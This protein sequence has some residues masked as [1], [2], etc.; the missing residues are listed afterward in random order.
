MAVH[1]ARLRRA[2]PALIITL[3]LGCSSQRREPPDDTRAG[4]AARTEDREDVDASESPS[5]EELRTLEVEFPVPDAGDIVSE[6]SSFQNIVRCR[7]RLEGLVAPAVGGVL[8]D[9][10]YDEVTRDACRTLRAL[11]SKQIEECDRL[12]IRATKLGC[13]RRY[14][15]YH[16]EPDLCPLELAG[17]QRDPSCVALAMRDP[18]MCYALFDAQKRGLCRA[19]ILRSARPCRVAHETSREAALCAAAAKRW[20]PVVPP[21]RQPAKLTVGYESTLRLCTVDAPLRLIADA[22]AA[23]AFSELVDGGLPNCRDSSYLVRRGALV[24]SDRRVVVGERRG[25]AFGDPI[26]LVELEFRIPPGELP[27]T[28]SVE[29]DQLDAWYAP[30]SSSL[31]P[32]SSELTSGELRLDRGAR[33]RGAIVAGLFC[34]DTGTRSASSSWTCGEFETFVR[35]ILPAKE[36]VQE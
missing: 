6:V 13:R 3:I 5:P 14:A 19:K 25:P 28:L 1:L 4:T 32:P 30:A 17:E 29:A 10:S 34:L 2:H 26:A 22:D 27:A 20:W 21:H 11:A 7:M 23:P 35:D 18:S 12:Q 24:N 36:G 8:A 31:V 33:A 9:L 15:M 16:G